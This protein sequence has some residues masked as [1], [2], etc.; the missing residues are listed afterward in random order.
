MKSLVFFVVAAATVLAVPVP[1]V[2]D[3]EL[4]LGK[5]T[6]FA[7]VHHVATKGVEVGVTAPAASFLF[8]V[9]KL[10]VE[11]G[12]FKS[13]HGLRHLEF[14]VLG[15]D[16]H[17]THLLGVSDCKGWFVVVMGVWTKA[18]GLTH[19]VFG[20]LKDTAGG[21]KLHHLADL[22]AGA[23]FVKTHAVSDFLKASVHGTAV[24]AFQNKLPS[25]PFTHKL[26]AK[27]ANLL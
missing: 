9:P 19:K 20:V 6:R 21:F 2:F 25:H 8:L 4:L 14:L 10:G 11:F 15:A 12:D 27:F 22:D 3:K 16:E 26:L 23:D 18:A 7:A 13:K 1:V 17:L 5:D 24:D